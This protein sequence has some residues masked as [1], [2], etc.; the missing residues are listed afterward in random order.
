MTYEP[1]L[2]SLFEHRGSHVP[3]ADLEALIGKHLRNTRLPPHGNGSQ[4]I[5]KAKN[6]SISMSTA[7]IYTPDNFLPAKI[8]MLGPRNAPLLTVP[9]STSV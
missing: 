3:V 1:A 6:Q 7:V 2:R 5:W 8:S 4:A 9:E